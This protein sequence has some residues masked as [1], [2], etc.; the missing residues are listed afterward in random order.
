MSPM[1][2]RVEK[3][4]Q[5]KTEDRDTDRPKDTQRQKLRDN[6]QRAEKEI[7]NRHTE[8]KKIGRGTKRDILP[9]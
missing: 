9:K 6:K 2:Q 7:S 1:R 3:K 8:D 4:R 5:I